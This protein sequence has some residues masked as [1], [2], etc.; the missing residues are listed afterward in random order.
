M[1]MAVL[2]AE[3]LSKRFGK[4]TALE[5]VSV[6]VGR[7]EIV[8]LLGQNGAGKSTL[9]KILVGVEKPDGGN[10]TFRDAPFAPRNPLEA[11]RN[12]ISIAYQEGA[13]VPDLK[14]FQWMYLGREVK[15]AL[16]ILKAG[17]MRKG[18]ASML[19]ELGINCSPDRLVRDLPT[20]SKKMIEIAKAIDVSRE[21]D[22]AIDVS[23]Q[24]AHKEGDNP[25]VIILD[26]PTAPLTENEREILY[27]KLKEIKNR[28]SFLLISHIIPEVLEIADR[29]YVLRDG[30]NAGVFDLRLQNVTEQMVYRAMF[31]EEI[32]EIGAEISGSDKTPSRELMIKVSN[33]SRKGV[34][35]D[36]SFE[37]SKGEII[38]LDG[39]PHSGKMEIVRTIA[40]IIEQDQGTIE[41]SGRI[42]ESGIGAR[43]SS[44][45]GCFSG[46]RSDELFLI[47][48]VIKNITIAV[49]DSLQRK[50]WVVPMIDSRKERALAEKMVGGLGIQP[51]SVDALM[52]NLSGGNM[53]KVGLAKWLLR[54]PDLL[55]LVNPT[56]GI[57]TKTKMEIHQILLRIRKEGRSIILVSEDAYEVRRLSDRILKIEHGRVSSIVSRECVQ[58]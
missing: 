22:R 47:W 14:V 26:E 3:H 20:V 5:D 41:K 17:E 55:V 35:H 25:S 43:I 50:R 29:I 38:S 57:D 31:G 7:N 1:S 49:L 13:T 45:I 15:N 24:E 52:R 4:I 33:I 21:G 12:G 10:L 40:G 51:P 53:Q 6:E 28:S 9:T 34:F 11:A 54:N 16:G 44:G 58:N 23:R 56:I 27:A 19:E 37:V 36:V 32:A 39:A 30:K 46:E 8:G 42:L 48:P 2:K 18:C